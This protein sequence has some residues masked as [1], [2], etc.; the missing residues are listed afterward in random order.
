RGTQFDPALVDAFCAAAG[1]LLLNDSD[2]PDSYEL[3]AAEPALQRRLTG[4]ELDA[5]L[6]VVADF[7]DLRSSY[8]AGHSRAVADL[9]ARAASVAGLTDTD[10]TLLRRAALL[11]DIGLHGVP[12]TI[13]DKPGKLSPS[14]H[15]RLRLSSYYT[16]R[17]LARPGPVAR[18]GAVAALACERM[19]GSGA[20]RGLSGPSIPVTGRILAA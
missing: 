16:E 18:I 12:T 5:A 11:H 4:D 10:T 13:L 15:E 8:R 7:T 2:E 1:D 17:V 6:E 14:D 9:A 3:I 20:H 19:D